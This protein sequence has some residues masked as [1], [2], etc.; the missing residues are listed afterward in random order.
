MILVLNILDLWYSN[1]TGCWP[2]SSV[3]VDILSGSR[4]ETIGISPTNRGWYNQEK[5]KKRGASN[6]FLAFI[7]GRLS[8]KI[9]NGNVDGLW[10][11]PKPRVLAVSLHADVSVPGRDWTFAS[12]LVT[13]NIPR[14]GLI[15]RGMSP[16][17]RGMIPRWKGLP[18]RF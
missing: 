18:F 13:K 9:V 11:G 2:T 15:L 10:S 5:K 4:G 8:Q 7:M 16:F 14:L 3:G 6:N 1:T 12:K 17:C